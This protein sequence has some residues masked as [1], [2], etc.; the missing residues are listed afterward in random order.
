MARNGDLVPAL[1]R[2]ADLV[3]RFPENRRFL[4]DYVAVLGWAERDEDVLT[5]SS[6]IDTRLA[7]AYVLETVGKSARNLR[8][9][10]RAVNAYRTAVDRYPDRLQARIGLALALTD[11]GAPQQALAELET[12]E[13]DPA[14]LNARAYAWRASGSLFEALSAYD[15][16]LR[17]DRNNPTAR[18][19]RIVVTLRLGAPH[20]AAEMAAASPGLLAP[21]EQAAVERD[22]RAVDIRWTRLPAAEEESRRRKRESIIAELE[23]AL[24]DMEAQGQGDSPEALRARFDLI[25]AYHEHADHDRAIV[26]YQPLRDS[27]AAVPGYVL[28]AV[29]GAHLARREPEAARRLLERALAQQPDDVDLQFA[30]FYAYVE[31]QAF[32][33]ALPL[34]DRLAANEPAWLG[35]RPHHRPNP[36]KLLADATAALGRA[37]ADDLAEAMRRFDTLVAGAPQNTDLRAERAYVYLWRGWPRLALEEFDIVLHQEPGHPNARKGRVDSL[38]ALAAFR[39]AD[40]SRRA[41]E[42]DRPDDRRLN[43][44]TRAW[45]VHRMRA[46]S[47]LAGGTTSSGAAEGTEDLALDTRIYSRPLDY[48]YRILGRHHVEQAEFPE[49]TAVYRRIGAGVD[50][51]ARNLE[52]VAELDRDAASSVNAGV[53]V[54]ARRFLNDH[55]SYILG[56][57]SYS[58]EVPLRG[59]LA[60]GID[61]WSADFAVDWRAH[62]SRTVHAGVQAQRFSDDNHRDA[63]YVNGFQRLISRARYKLDGRMELYAS[64]NTRDGAPYFNPSRDFAA[65]ATVMQEWLLHR[66]YDRSFRHRLATTVGTYRQQGFGS[67]ATWMA[68]YEHQWNPDDRTGLTYGLTRARRVYDGAAEY[69]TGAYLNLDWRF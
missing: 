19:G 39:Q 47:V 6:R 3:A 5:H 61:G 31:T 2:L 25:V 28:E 60:E 13:D 62:E 65:D 68:R 45:E 56:L 40:R 54:E 48:H 53:A 23:Q 24:T 10:P 51:R 35:Q 50:Y 29:A 67:G 36:D 11:S 22:R 69:Q 46:L 41:L 37:F 15:Q 20:L 42:R 66:R 38:Q 58:D 7:P 30:L 9:Y 33:Q 17:L 64:R 59:R 27:A 55:W 44:L 1:E 49:G 12:A 21:G 63:L 16:A 26:L 8:Q 43:P 18:R 14:V 34:I 52:I 57:D 32:D 4:H